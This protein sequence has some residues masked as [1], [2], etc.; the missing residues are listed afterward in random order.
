MISYE[1]QRHS[2][3][4]LSCVVCSF[5]TCPLVACLTLDVVAYGSFP[6]TQFSSFPFSKVTLFSIILKPIPK[7]RICLGYFLTVSSNTN[8]N[9]LEIMSP[10]LYS[11]KVQASLSKDQ[12]RQGIFHWTMFNILLCM[13]RPF[14][15]ITACLISSKL[16]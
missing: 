4:T 14:L 3:R 13:G 12:N 10:S 15:L 16:G 8:G 7:M 1:K 9:S 11:Y 6:C 2:G 5:A